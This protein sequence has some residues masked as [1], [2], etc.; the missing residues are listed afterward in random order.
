MKYF[1]LF[2]VWTWV[3]STYAAAL[4]LWRGVQCFRGAWACA[5]MPVTDMMLVGGSTV[6]A[7]FFS[8]FV[9]AMA[10]DQWEGAVTNTTAIES[11]RQWK[12]EERGICRGLEDVC[13]APPSAGWLL[14]TPLRAKYAWSPLDDPD[15]WDRRDPTIIA[16]F[17]KLK[18]SLERLKEMP[19]A[20][21]APE[22]GEPL[23]PR[24]R[25]R[26]LELVGAAAAGAAAAGAAGEAPSAGSAGSSV[27]ASSPAPAPS[28]APLASPA[29]D[30]GSSETLD[31]VLP[32]SKGAAGG[33]SGGPKQRRK[34]P[35]T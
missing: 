22:G 19:P 17:Q 31:E 26:Y 14:P 2:L 23:L 11:M 5:A 16:H 3:G 13:A 29:P 7:I 6:L 25:A 8:I 12:E 30:S 10:C 9:V 20:L 27:S 15:A 35:V 32:E 21:P 1:V 28:P 33:G 4:A 34:P 24:L 18:D